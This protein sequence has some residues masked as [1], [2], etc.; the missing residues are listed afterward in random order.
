MFEELDSQELI[1]IRVPD[2]TPGKGCQG[3][4]GWESAPGRQKSPGI[5]SSAVLA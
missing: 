3:G 5:T 2:L 4:T 1:P